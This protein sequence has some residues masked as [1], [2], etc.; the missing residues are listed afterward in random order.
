MAPHV[1]ELTGYK[2]DMVTTHAWEIWEEVPNTRHFPGDD[3]GNARRAHRMAEAIPE[4]YREVEDEHGPPCDGY[5]HTE[6][7]DALSK[8]LIKSKKE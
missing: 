8:K 4:K 3:T 7:L 6:L 5:T 2:A 1:E